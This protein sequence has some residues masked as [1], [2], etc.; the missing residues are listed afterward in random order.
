MAKLRRSFVLIS[1]LTAARLTIAQDDLKQKFVGKSPCAPEL[2]SEHSD[3]G[4]RLD[5]TQGLQFIER[6]RDNRQVLLIV[7]YRDEKD[8]CGVIHDVVQITRLGRQ[9]HFEFRVMTPRPPM[10]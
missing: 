3:C 1:F 5:K 7:Q 2:Q 9:K 10:T 6:R 8:G 4:I